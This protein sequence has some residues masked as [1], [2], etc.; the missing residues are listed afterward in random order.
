MLT[1]PE[2][3]V[4]AVRAGIV[5]GSAARRGEVLVRPIPRS[6]SVHGIE[7][8][9]EPVMFTKQAGL[10]SHL[11]GDDPVAA[12][13]S[14]CTLLAE[15]GLAPRLHPAS[16]ASAAWIHPVA[17][18][19]VAD[20]AFDQRE[21]E[22]TAVRLGESLALLHTQP[23][24]E[25]SP[26][27]ALPPWPLR[28]TLPPS[29]QST[30]STCQSCCRARADVLAVLHHDAVA[31]ILRRLRADWGPQAWTH[32]DI[33]LANLLLDDSAGDC[34]VKLIDWESAGLGIPEWDLVSAEAALHL[35]GDVAPG[36]GVFR[37]AYRQAGGTAVGSPAWRCVR[38]LVSAWQFTGHDT[39]HQVES[40]RRALESVH[41]HADAASKFGETAR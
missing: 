1:S 13:A 12:E 21:L 10:A 33:S 37:H 9:G 35:L 23:T 8:G 29:M 5:S 15:S 22:T 7:A 28:T 30:D 14:T 2:L 26:A 27:T 20:L 34:A 18:R 16:D 6:N 25:G 3:L 31:A 11:D 39:P 17:G 32:G 19:S 36:A 38:E 40:V 24:D 41:V 4:A